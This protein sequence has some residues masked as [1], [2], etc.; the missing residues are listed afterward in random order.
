MVSVLLVYS[1]EWRW[2]VVLLV[3]PTQYVWPMPPTPSA[4]LTGTAVMLCA[5]HCRVCGVCGV[6]CLSKVFVWWGIPCV[7]PPR[8]GGGGWLSLGGGALWG[9]GG[10]TSEGRQCR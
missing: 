9:W 6:L 4:V 5:V 8:R 7:L 3:C 1:I 2:C 10:M